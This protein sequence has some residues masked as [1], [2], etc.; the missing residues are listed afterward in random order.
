M[1]HL[2]ILKYAHMCSWPNIIKSIT[3]AANSF[4]HKKSRLY[5]FLILGLRLN[6]KGKYTGRPD[7]MSHRKWR[8]S[9]QQLSWWPDLTLLGCCLVSLYFLCKI[10]SMSGRPVEDANAR[11]VQRHPGE[12]AQWGPER[13]ECPTVAQDA[14]TWLYH[15]TLWF[16][17][18]TIKFA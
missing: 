2:Q 4:R 18:I 3:G 1:S 9:K 8:E 6:G 14:D 17:R 10:M 13:I 15:S 16:S 7:R 11:P 5:S 12:R